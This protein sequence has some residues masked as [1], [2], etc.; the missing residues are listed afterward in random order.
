MSDIFANHEAHRLA[1]MIAQ[2]TEERDDLREALT[3]LCRSVSP[4]GRELQ[5]DS[6]TLH[7]IAVQLRPEIADA[8]QT[9]LA[10]L[11]KTDGE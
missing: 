3:S 5:D 6:E 4:F 9:A 7:I 10:N 2:L 8:Y 1:Q 11:N